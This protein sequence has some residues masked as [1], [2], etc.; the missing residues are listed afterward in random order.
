M[1]PWRRMRYYF[2]HLPSGKNIIKI[3]RSL[4]VFSEAILHSTN[5]FFAVSRPGAADETDTYVN[6]VAPKARIYLHLICR[7]RHLPL[8]LRKGKTIGCDAYFYTALMYGAA[9]TVSSVTSTPG[10][11]T[12]CRT[13]VARGTHGFAGSFEP[14]SRNMRIR[15][16]VNAPLKEAGAACR[17]GRIQQLRR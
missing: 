4:I 14:G 15:S 3:G 9:T 8:K 17:R 1:S 12:L 11:K 13:N 16:C 6:K 10:N 2:N 7:K 5:T